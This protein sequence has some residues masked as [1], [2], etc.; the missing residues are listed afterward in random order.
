MISWIDSRSA[1]QFQLDLELTYIAA[2]QE[3]ITF[4]D[5]RC[6]ISAVFTPDTYNATK[7]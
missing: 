4:R 2:I 1:L 3:K 7:F 6:L 5:K